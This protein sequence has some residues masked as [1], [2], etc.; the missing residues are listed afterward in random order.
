VFVYDDLSPYYENLEV[1]TSLILLGENRNTTI[2]DGSGIDAVVNV[3]ADLVT[4]SGFTIQNAGGTDYAVGISVYGDNCIIMGCYIVN[5]DFGIWLFESDNTTISSVTLNSNRD[6]IRVGGEN[7]AANYVTI[8]NNFIMGSPGGGIEIT[9]KCF[10]PYIHDNYIANCFTGVGIDC[11][12]A[13]VSNNVFQ[14]NSVPIYL[15]SQGTKITSNKINSNRRGSVEMQYCRNCII[16]KNEFSECGIWIHGGEIEYFNHSISTDNS[17]NGKP[18]Y[19]FFNKYIN[20][21]GWDIGQLILVKCSGVVTNISISHTSYAIQLDHC[22]N[23]TIR[24]SSLTNNGNGIYLIYSDDN[25]IQYNEISNNSR[26]GCFLNI[27]SSYNQILHNSFSWNVWGIFVN[28]NHNMISG[29]ILHKNNEKGIYLNG[30]S[31]NTISD[32]IITNSDYGLDVGYSGNNTIVR[33]SIKSNAVYGI[34]IFPSWTSDNNTIYH[35]NFENNTNNALDMGSNTWDNGYTSGGNYWSDYN[36]TD[37]II[38]GIG[39]APYNISGGSS[40]DR[41]PLML[42]YGMTNFTITF[43]RRPFN[44]VLSIKNGGT[45][46][47]L[48]VQFHI[49]IKGGFFVYARDVGGVTRPLVPGEEIQ[50]PTRDFLFGFGHIY[51]NVSI[52]ADNAPTVSKLTNGFLV[53]FFFFHR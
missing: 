6:N 1:D 7:T 46:T 23:V 38:P 42:P 53:L 28:D 12:N 36:G 8:N 11:N 24:N 10:E 20:I 47:V 22:S 5:N 2:I 21:D 50:I 30:A 27:V 16:S 44:P 29:N 37:E 25:S 14:N 34:F 35:N 19:Y 49:T 31:Y 48:N 40:Q 9:H 39:D 43:L 41:Y 33:N 13:T 51:I 4:I 18:L 17:V 32:N 52:W 45:T 3:S 26:Y 15:S